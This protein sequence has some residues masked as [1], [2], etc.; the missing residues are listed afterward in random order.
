MATVYYFAMVSLA[1]VSTS[2]IASSLPLAIL[3]VLPTWADIA[4]AGGGVLLAPGSIHGVSDTK[5]W[6][7]VAKKRL[8]DFE[9]NQD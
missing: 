4:L 6:V 5:H 8:S 7:N 2:A 1:A 9:S 3:D